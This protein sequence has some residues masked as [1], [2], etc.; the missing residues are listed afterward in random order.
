MPSVAIVAIDEL[1][2]LHT[3]PGAA[4]DNIVEAHLHTLFEPEM[5]GTTGVVFI[6]T[7]AVAATLPQA[8]VK[9]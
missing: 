9:V 6:E 3:P 1:L 2:A 4:S 8:L 7:D 5:A